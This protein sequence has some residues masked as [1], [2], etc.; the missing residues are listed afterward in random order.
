MVAIFPLSLDATI[1]QVKLHTNPSA[2]QFLGTTVQLTASAVDSDPG[3]LTYKWEVETPGSSTYT[4]LEDFST[5][6]YFTWA[7]HYTE[8]TYQLR[9][10]ARDYLAGTS[11]QVVVAYQVNPLVTGTQPVAVP[12]ANPLVALFSAPTCAAGSTMS[13]NFQTPGSKDTHSTAPQTCHSGSMNFYIAGMQAKTTYVMT[14][15]VTSGTTVTPGPPVSFTTGVIPMSL[16]FPTMSVPVPPGP[17]TGTGDSLVLTGYAEPP[18]F[19]VATD[20]NANI[21][22]YYPYYVQL[23]RPVFGGTMLSIPNGP[24]TGTGPFGAGQTREQVVRESDLTGNIVHQTSCDRVYEQLSAMGMTDPLGMFDHDAIRLAN[25]ETMVLGMV[26][27]IFPAGT[28]GSTAPVDIIGTVIVILDD[29]FQVIGY[30]NA[31]DHDCSGTGC[32]NINRVGNFE[33]A[34]NGQGVTPGGCPPVLLISPA[35]DWTHANSLEYLP[36]DG[37]LL[38]SVRDQ[39]WVV[40]IDY[41]NGIGTGDIL[42]RLGI[43][44]DFKLSGTQGISF[45]W[46][47]GQHDAGF[48]DNQE[49]TFMVFDDGTTRHSQQGGDSRGQVWSI[50]QTNMIATLVLNA[51]LGAYSPSLGSAQLLQNGD[52]MFQSGNIKSGSSIMVQNSEFTPTGT[53]V[54]EFQSVGP[55]PSY[56]AW[57]MTDLYH[58]TFDGSSGPM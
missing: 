56:R 35:N 2:P 11:A 3:P 43:G 23:T 57:R 30:W 32:I 54:Y 49:L 42:W 50:D 10:T 45:P 39:N 51:D 24:G 25:G 53:N 37:D 17:L 38:V 46:F 44:G 16:S 34:V 26:Q 15:Q 8:G 21:I 41:N 31:F 28:Q 40:K 29:N 33:C 52:Y 48:V 19:P 18:Q 9:L 6:N 4:T 13:V 14:Y 55:V 58:S 27:R 1:S 22:W 7:P 47:S 36:S 5:A 20:L 12:T